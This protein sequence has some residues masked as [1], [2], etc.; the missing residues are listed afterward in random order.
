MFE[1]EARVTLGEERDAATAKSALEVCAFLSKATTAHAVQ[2]L[3][4]LATRDWYFR[5]RVCCTEGRYASAGFASLYPG[6][7]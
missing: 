2:F 5:R 3:R 7:V 1:A 6:V 4:S